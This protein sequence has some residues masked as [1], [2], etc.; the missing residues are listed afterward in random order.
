MAIVDKFGGIHGAFSNLVYRTYRNMRILQMKPKKVKQ[1]NNSKQAGKEFGLCATTGRIMR[2]VFH[3][4]YAGYDG[5]MVN[6]LCGVLRQSITASKTKQRGER[7]LHDGEL[8]FLEGFQFNKNSPLDKVMKVRPAV[9]LNQEGKVQVNL[10]AIRKD[11]LFTG[12]KQNHRWYTL[13]LT[14]AS[15]DFKKEVYS[16]I[17]YRDLRIRRGMA[18][19]AQEWVFDEVLPANRVI[20]LS[21]SLH[22]YKQD[23]LDG[24]Q[25]INSKEWSPAEII[26]AWHTPPV[27]ESNP[28][29]E[30]K[31]EEKLEPMNDYLGNKILQDI[32]AFQALIPP[33]EPNG[34]REKR[35]PRYIEKPE[36]DLPNGDIK[37]E[38]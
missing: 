13:R 27:Q 38:K 2:D 14:L 29:E 1:T 10:P 30:L 33:P 11:Q 16:Y 17:G 32:L 20:V 36:F 28:D 5:E 8:S 21:M 7:D 19:D 31:V 4:I 3:H 9:S 6:R 37:F 26:G 12:P 35:K 24:L 18:V 25:S 22:A 34:L 15:F 23:K